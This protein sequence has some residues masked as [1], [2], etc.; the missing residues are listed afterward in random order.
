MAKAS[1]DTLNELHGA[2]AQ[3]LLDRVYS[4]EATAAEV[5][6]AVKMLKDN[7]IEAIPKPHNP[8]GQLSTSM[9]NLPFTDPD[10]VTAH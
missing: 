6:Q 2:V 5:G 9:S 7:G 8:L 3:H 10:D 4:G 1:N